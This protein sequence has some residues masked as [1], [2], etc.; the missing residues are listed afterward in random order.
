[1]RHPFIRK[2]KRNNHLMDMIDRY[3]NW[4]TN[5]GNETDSDSDSEVDT[6]NNSDDSDWNMTVKGSVSPYIEEQSNS[7]TEDNKL[8]SSLGSD[9]SSSSSQLNGA[10][11]GGAPHSQDSTAPSSLQSEP[12]NHKQDMSQSM[13]QLNVGDAQNATAGK[14]NKQQTN[15]ASITRSD[16]NIVS[17]K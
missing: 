4:M 3:K 13:S 17:H 12:A 10:D 6:T 1:M 16:M 9:S 8:L 5:H 15:G 7:Q 11:G 14:A 2:A